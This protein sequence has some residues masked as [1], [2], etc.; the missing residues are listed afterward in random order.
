MQG[1]LVES[2]ERGADSQLLSKMVRID[3]ELVASSGI[4]A[5]DDHSVLSLESVKAV[6]NEAFPVRSGI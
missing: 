4:V 3:K 6:L 2:S 5:V 1:H